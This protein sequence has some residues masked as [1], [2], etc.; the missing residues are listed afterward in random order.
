MRVRG[1]A[2]CVIVFSIIVSGSQMLGATLTERV[3][4][5]GRDFSHW[6]DGTGQWQVVGDVFLNAENE[7]LLGSKPGAG[8]VLNGPTGRTVHLFSGAEFGD[9]RA[10]V[11]FAVA[12]GSNSGV[13]FQGRYEIQ[14]LDSW[15]VE[16]GQLKHGDCG[17]IYER[18]DEG[19]G[20][21]KKGYDGRAPR[22][23]AS[24]EPG[25]WQTF[26]VVF[27]A[28]RFDKAGRKISNARFEK[29]VHNGV[30]VHEDVEVYGPTRASAWEDEKPL[31]P[32][33]LQGDH[34]PVA[35]RNIWIE[36]AG[37]LPFYAMDTALRDG[38][39]DTPGK[40]ATVLGEL[41]YSGFGT[42]GCS[43]LQALIEKL[44]E[45]DLR[46][47]TTYVW[48]NIDPGQ[49]KYEPGLKDAIDAF[50]GRNGILWLYVLGKKTGSRAEDD[51]RAV[52]IVRE[53]G[54]MAAQKGVR[55]ALYPHTGFYVET[56]EDAVRIVRQV[57]EDQGAVR[58]NV[59]V[60]FNLCHWLKVGSEHDVRALIQMAMPHL[61]VVSINGADKGGQDWKQLIQ[62][63]GRGTFDVCGFLRTLGECGYNGPL[64]FQGYGIGGDSRENLK[65]T[66]DAWRELSACM[67]E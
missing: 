44:D 20:E 28:P 5:T 24:S 11:E 58:R 63:L 65:R 14:I 3:Y 60:T 23:N 55:V 4:L 37:P 38:K 40:I 52:G 6:R 12:K 34:G 62:P 56:V 49:Q 57:Q 36:P 9:V 18:W 67:G 61:F 59:G 33:M 25:Q 51:A 35:Y 26:D 43:G 41:G 16:Q 32:L 2:I 53:I 27:R 15:G 30:V 7:G 17:G 66:M 22:V 13:Y 42:S 47:Y 50:E 39:Y 54:D 64:A 48:A 1:K 19:R 8:A 29:V 10:H 45:K 21:G 46:L 31:G